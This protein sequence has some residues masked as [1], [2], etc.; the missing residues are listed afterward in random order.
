MIIAFG[1][2]LLNVLV[3]LLAQLRLI[4]LGWVHHALYFWVFISSLAALILLREL[5]LILTVACLALFPRAKPRTWL[6]PTLASV[7][8]IGYVLAIRGA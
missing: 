4:H 1:S 6:H 3:G 7:G 5:W 8:L 2:Y